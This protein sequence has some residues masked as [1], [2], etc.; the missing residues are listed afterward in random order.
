[1]AFGTSVPELAAS[2]V[3][4]LR[5]Q[6][7]LVLGN[8]VG[9]NIF[10]VTLVLGAAALVRPLPVS[11]ELLRL[12]IP[13]MIVFSLLLLPLAFTQLRVDRWEGGLLLAGYAAFLFLV[14]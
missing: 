3:A 13:A 7:D 5:G 2:V 9:S 8:V 11:P 12:E 1:V 10:N 6:A 14:F 4:A